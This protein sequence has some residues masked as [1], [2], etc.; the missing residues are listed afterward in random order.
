MGNSDLYDWSTFTDPKT[1]LEL[2]NNSVRDS[3]KADAYAGRTKFV[4]IALT[5]LFPLSTI[6]AMGLDGASTSTVGGTSNKRFGFKARIIGELSPHLFL[7]NPCDPAYAP[8]ADGAYSIISLHTTFLTQATDEPP[9]VTRGDIVHVELEKSNATIYNLQY[10]RFLSLATVQDSGGSAGTA[11]TGSV[12]EIMSSVFEAGMG[13]S[14]SFGGLV[15]AI[16]APCPTCTSPVPPSIWRINSPYYHPSV[17]T[18][19]VLSAGGTA[20]PHAGIDL[21]CAKDGSTDLYAIA[22]GTIKNACFKATKSCYSGGKCGSCKNA[23]C[24]YSGNGLHL[25]HTDPDP[26]SGKQ[27]VT[28]YKH[29]T[30]LAVGNGTTV[31]KGDVIGK[32]GNTGCSSG[33]H[34]HFEVHIGKPTNWTTAV[35]PCEYLGRGSCKCRRAGNRAAGSRRKQCQGS[36]ITVGTCLQTG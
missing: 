7:P 34:L 28:V 22:D 29:M 2:L 19:R 15:P 16:G 8:D 23:P 35:D 33:A 27:I 20:V 5:N 26:T 36:G 11:A 6:Q 3:L 4:A 18:C 17:G 12:C 30:N 14:G 24:G 31:A 25:Y 21:N 1:G 9:A 10:G 13:I 32:C